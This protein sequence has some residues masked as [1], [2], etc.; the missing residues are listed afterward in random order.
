M[1]KLF[2]QKNIS[3]EKESDIRKQSIK[4]ISNS[5]IIMHH[6]PNIHQLQAKTKVSPREPASGDPKENWLISV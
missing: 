2:F 3:S 1:K 6:E 5:I 4:T